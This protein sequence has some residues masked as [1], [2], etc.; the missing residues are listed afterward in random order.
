MVNFN[1]EASLAGGLRVNELFRSCFSF[2]R[3]S[4]LVRNDWTETPPAFVVCSP[5]HKR[6]GF[7]FSVAAEGRAV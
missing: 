6:A 7:I 3:S 5:I 4:G 1:N 2:A